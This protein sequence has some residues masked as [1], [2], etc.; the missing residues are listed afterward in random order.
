M[1]APQFEPISVDVSTG[2]FLVRGGMEVRGDLMVFLN[3]H[4]RASFPILDA[5]LMPDG[6]EYRVATIKQASFTV[7]QERVAFVAVTN[8][9][10]A[11]TIQYVQ[12]SR[13]VVFYTNWF[14][15]RGDLHVSVE[16]R[17][18]ELM[19]P[20]K[21]FFAL[22]N[23]FVAP[24]RKMTHKLQPQYPL[25]AIQRTTVVGYHLYEKSSMG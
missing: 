14:A 17:D 9:K 20:S 25:M 13:P 11:Q 3:D 19:D 4:N 2:N 7:A 8:E 18:D 16:A 24:I 12:S 22:T 5:Q 6:P 1:E 21:D 15:I 23:A 10:D